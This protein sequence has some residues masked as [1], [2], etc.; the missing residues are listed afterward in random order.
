M[1]SRLHWHEPATDGGGAFAVA[2]SPLWLLWREDAAPD[3]LGQD[4]GERDGLV[5]ARGD[6]GLRLEGRGEL[7]IF[8]G[9]DDATGQAEHELPYGKAAWV[10][11]EDHDGPA[12][13]R[14]EAEGQAVVEDPLIGRELGG[15]RILDRLGSGA[16]GVV[17]RALQIKLDREVALKVLNPGVARQSPLAVASFK[18]EAVAAGR[19]SHPNLVQVYDV[20]HDQKL[21][22]YSMEMVPGGDLEDRLAASGPVP[23]REAVDYLIDCA[24]ALAFAE[25]HHLVHRDV[26][27]ENLMLTVD[28]RAK[29][30]DLGMAATRNMLEKESAGGTPHFMAPECLGEGPVDH[31]ADLYSLGCTMFRL[32]TGR[33]PFEASAVKDILRAHR[34]EEVPALRDHGVDAPAAMQ[35]LLEALMAKDP[36]ARPQHAREV[37][38]ALH[39]LLERKRSPLLTV[40]M[41]VI[42]L[43]AV[44]TA[45]YFAFSGP[46]KSEPETVIVE[47]D[48][49]D[50][51]A[52]EAQAAK[53]RRELAFTQAMA[54]VEGPER[55]AALERFQADHPDSEFAAEVEAE[56][57]R[58]AALPDPGTEE[59]SGP[60]PQEVLRQQLAAFEA[61]WNPLLE[62]YR[63]GAAAASLAGATLPAELLAP[64]QLRLD[65]TVAGRFEQWRGEHAQALGAEDF[66]AASALRSTVEGSFAGVA[67]VPAWQAFLAELGD[68]AVRVE[69]AARKRDFDEARG[70]AVRALQEQVL[71]RW[72]RLDYAAAADAVAAAAA[73]CA[74]PGMAAELGPRE[75]PFRAAASAAA[76]LFA[77]L[78]SKPDLPVTE[79]RD[80]KRAF[81]QG[82]DGDGLALLVQVRGERTP[83][84][85]PWPTFQTPGSW[86]GLLETVLVE[87]AGRAGDDV[88]LES[89]Y[90]LH[91]MARLASTVRSWD[92]VPTGVQA[93]EFAREAEAWLAGMRLD[94]S[95]RPTWMAAEV[96][97]IQDLA[98]FAG[99]VA[100]GNDYLA[101][102]ALDRLGQRFSLVG[103][104]VSDGQ[105]TWGLTP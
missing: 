49:G 65:Q 15:Y 104:W 63:F 59:P 13:W 36:E 50:A 42:A 24:E 44:G 31:R 66:A 72:E 38:E 9:D 60:D 12:R 51:A 53:L 58:L 98:S 64:L 80:G 48:N 61:E 1:S 17:Y 93:A 83:R 54:V 29:L 11:F 70:A 18:R 68:E 69:A 85:D 21:H 30:A 67:A 62:A 55:A 77:T 37:A 84:L 75:A 2:G 86:R 103:A 25:E 27:P 96:A 87:E 82:A 95:A 94:P 39:D 73:A 56:L 99:N 46:G 5:V 92:R 78:E 101:L 22:F 43:G 33:T 8:L 41:S 4:P 6:R 32:L 47:V 100:Q 81:A 52:A 90:L 76:E 102:Q 23:W 34:D 20:G 79:P 89:L 97:A 28:G 7:R 88:E 40:A 74:H 91:G 105:A 10:D 35:D 19:L 14:L 71:P 16:V 3:R 45:L 26:K 57:A